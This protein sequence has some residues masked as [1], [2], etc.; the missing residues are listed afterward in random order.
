M[1]KCPQT[2]RAILTGIKTDRESFRCS[3]VFFARAHCSICQTNHDWFAKEAWVYEPL[4]SF[5]HRSMML[6]LPDDVL[7]HG[8]SETKE[9]LRWPSCAAP[10]VHIVHRGV[11]AQMKQLKVNFCTVELPRVVVRSLRNIQ[12][13]R[14]ELLP[15]TTNL[16]RAAAL[17]FQIKLREISLNEIRVIRARL[18]V[19]NR[20]SDVIAWQTPFQIDAPSM[21]PSA[22]AK[23]GPTG[24]A[25]GN[26]PTRAPPTQKYSLRTSSS[27]L[28]GC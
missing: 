10:R 25:P 9:V 14:K 5:G 27:Q 1:I 7:A 17:A 15:T 21:P 13:A 11:V 18:R 19:P 26:E 8:A 2:G 12:E 24:F 22:R 3:A 4:G 16:P 28:I 20:S 6:P 23:V